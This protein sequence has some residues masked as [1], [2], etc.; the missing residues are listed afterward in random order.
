LPAGSIIKDAVQAAGGFTDQADAARIN[1]ALELKDQQQIHVPA[2]AE[3]S[4]PPPV[5][6]GVEPV[7]VLTVSGDS[8]SSPAVININTASLE[9]LD[10]LPGIGPAIGQRII[11]F[12]Q[13]VGRFQSIDELGQVSGIGPATLTKIKDKITVD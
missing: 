7:A 3:E 12:R 13:N 10:S 1:L 11:D 4:P 9:E 6:G 8:P 5:Q 2:L